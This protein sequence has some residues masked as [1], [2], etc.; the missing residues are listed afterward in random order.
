MYPYVTLSPLITSSTDVTT[1][2]VTTT[3]VTTTS[4]LDVTICPPTTT[5]SAAAAAADITPDSATTPS[6][7]SSIV[8]AITGHRIRLSSSGQWISEFQIKLGQRCIWTPSTSPL[9]IQS[10]KLLN[11]VLK[12]G[13]TEMAWENN[14]V[15]FTQP[16]KTKKKRGE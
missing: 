7:E 10:L 15:T 6:T 2:D 12:N 13:P 5:P 16:L 9:I 8:T 1:T 14:Q 4:S 11:L 3:D